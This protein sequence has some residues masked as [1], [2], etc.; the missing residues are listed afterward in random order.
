M[1]LQ[2]VKTIP[3]LKPVY[4]N[5]PSTNNFHIPISGSSSRLGIFDGSL[6]KSANGGALITD[7][8]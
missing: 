6:I 2:A 4:L 8:H 1:L 3:T 7:L 5:D